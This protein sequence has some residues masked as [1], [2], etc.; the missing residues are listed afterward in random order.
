MKG[1]FMLRMILLLAALAISAYTQD[2]SMVGAHL[3]GQDKKTTFLGT[4]TFDKYDTASLMNPYSNY[5]SKYSATSIFNTYG[6]FG[7]EYSDV[8]PY[9]KYA[10]KP[11]LIVGIDGTGVYLLA[12]VSLNKYAP[13][14][15]DFS[16]TAPVI[17][18]DNL[19]GF[20][21]FGK[22]DPVSIAA[23][24]K[25]APKVTG[26]R[27]DALGRIQGEAH[28]PRISIPLRK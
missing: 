11:P 24:R 18:P 19:I 27:V 23:T 1:G 28:T 14:P 15:D 8:S 7:G 22:C 21:R 12:I 2:C 13:M 5:G 26:R 3:F 9:Y 25:K 6:D 20:L 16:G 10:T 17:T 4:I